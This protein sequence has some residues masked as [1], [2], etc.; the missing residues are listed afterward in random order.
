MSIAKNFTDFLKK[1]D[2]FGKTIVFCVDQE[3]AEELRK[4]INNCNTDIAKENPDYV[5]RVVSDEG[6]IGRGFLDRFMDVETLVPTVV[7]TSQ[8]LTTGVDVPPCRNIVL[9]RV[10]NSMTDFKQIIGRGTLVR[11]DYGKLYF[12]IVDYTGSATRLRILPLRLLGVAPLLPRDRSDA[13]SKTL[14]RVDDTRPAPQDR[15]Q[16]RLWSGLYYLVPTRCGL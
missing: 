7:T 6:Q 5:V 12:N 15:A 8:M 2:R 13:G 11:D 1:T 4:A 9:A 3:H 10:I 14:R 16:W